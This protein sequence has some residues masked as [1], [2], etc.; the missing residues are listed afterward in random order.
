V[1]VYAPAPKTGTAMCRF[2]IR[3][4]FTFR[5]IDTLKEKGAT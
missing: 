2:A 5:A 1:A 4:L 3:G